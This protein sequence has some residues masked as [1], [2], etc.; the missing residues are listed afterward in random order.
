MARF[1]DRAT[2]VCADY[3]VANARIHVIDRV[4]G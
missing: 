3:D 1:D 2:T 4:L